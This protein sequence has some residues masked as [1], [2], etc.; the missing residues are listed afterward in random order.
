MVSLLLHGVYPRGRRLLGRHVYISV[1]KMNIMRH[2]D[3]GYTISDR[4]SGVIKTRLLSV[5]FAL[6]GND[7][8]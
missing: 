1:S 4:W 5:S 6:V 7:R 2:L 3:T 8:T